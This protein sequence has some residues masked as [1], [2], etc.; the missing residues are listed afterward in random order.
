M[1]DKWHERNIILLENRLEVLSP[2]KIEVEALSRKDAT[3]L[4]TDV[5]R[6]FLFT[7]IKIINSELSN[8]M[9]V[10]VSKCK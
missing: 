3:Y 4:T 6:N 8:K 2:L 1:S 10:N 7:K 9:Y 5:I